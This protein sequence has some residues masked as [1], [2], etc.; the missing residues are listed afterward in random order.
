MAVSKCGDSYTQ[1]SWK[2]DSFYPTFP[3][4]RQ[5]FYH[6]DTPVNS[7]TA[8]TAEASVPVFESHSVDK[9]RRYCE[10][11]STRAFTARG[12]S[13]KRCQQC[14]LG[15]STCICAW[16]R[17]SRA[18]VEFVLLMHRDEVFKPTNTGR[19]IADLFPQQCHAFLWDRT[20][21]P[22]ELLQLLSDPQRHCLLVFPPKEGDGRQVKHHPSPEERTAT[23][24]TVILLDG[25]WKQARKMYTQSTWM[26]HLPLLDLNMAITEL[27]GELGHYKVR[28]ACESG[29]LATAEAAALCLHAAGDKR[30]S[31]H[32][33]N[34]FSVFNEHYV[35]ARMNRPALRVAAHE[36]LLGYV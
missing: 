17:P 25:T 3:P 12:Y 36:E 22:A 6:G 2:P 26:K 28:Q 21:P 14:L 16:R 8:P 33:L 13:L 15:L 18:G 27:D 4:L 32:V 19:L 5:F 24:T 23:I 20:Q 31:R 10:S 34:Y 30:N 35:A 9:L 11:Q 7:L 1:P 29:R